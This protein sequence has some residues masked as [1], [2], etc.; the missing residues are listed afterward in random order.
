[1][2]AKSLARQY[3][4]HIV[5]QFPNGPYRLGGYS[6]GG[7]MAYETACL[8][9]AQGAE[10]QFLVMIGAPYAYNQFAGLINKKI[11]AIMLRLQPY[12]ERTAMPDSFEILRA[13]FLDGGLQY[14]LK[15]LVGYR[16][17]GYTG[18]INYFQGKWAVSRFLGTHRTWRRH[19][20]GPFELHMLPGNH[21]SFMKP[22]HVKTLAGRLRQ[23]LADLD[24][25]KGTDK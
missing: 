7:L 15:S 4:D 24:S 5:K 16:P 3:A 9:K 20:K 12:Y 19:A 6:A 10:V 8:L 1:M 2:T 11:R 18:K 25:N 14:H 21:D 23:C 13:V 22:P 17:R